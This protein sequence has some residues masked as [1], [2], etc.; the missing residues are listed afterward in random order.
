MSIFPPTKGFLG[1]NPHPSG[2]SSLGSYFPLKI[3]AF[4]TPS[5]SEYPMT[6]CGGGMDIFRNHT[7]NTFAVSSRILKFLTVV[8]LKITRKDVKEQE[9]NH[10]DWQESDKYI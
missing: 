7:L 3:L 1:L 6:L 8:R 5:S 10:V 2:N 9:E 4:K